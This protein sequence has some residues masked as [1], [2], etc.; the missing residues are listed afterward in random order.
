MTA[1]V[2]LAVTAAA[3]LGLAALE[4]TVGVPGSDVRFPAAVNL[5]VSGKPVQF[6]LTGTA[7]RK[8]FVFSVYAIG[9]YVQAGA[10]VR[11][12]E[13]L[14]AADV[15]KMLFLVLERDVDGS[16]MIA[17]LREAVR[18]NYPED[19]FAAEFA[20]LE[21]QLQEIKIRKGDQ[22]LLMHAPGVGLQVIHNQQERAVVRNGAFSKAVWD[23]Y[24]GPNNLGDEIKRGLASR[25]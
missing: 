19:A 11:T 22:V 1:H 5:P 3:G 20:L 7:L 10:A 17:A 21:R 6:A 23:I 2:L 25:L 24:F 13:E 8:K 4:D 12:P 15:P 18:K 14:A 16:D 9:S